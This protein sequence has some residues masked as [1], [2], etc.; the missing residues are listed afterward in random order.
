MK[1][2]DG[3]R[4]QARLLQFTFDPKLAKAYG[5]DLISPGSYRLNSIL[6]VIQKQG[7]LS[8]AH[9]PHHY[10]HEPSI[11]KKILTDWERGGR[12]YVLTNSLN[13]G[14]Y[15]QLE[16]LAELRGL[17]KKESLHTVVVNLSS[18]EVM[19][20]HLPAHLLHGGGVDPAL[21]SRRKCSLK[22]AYLKA[23]SFVAQSLQEGDARWAQEA[24][25]Q[26][27]AE[28]DKLSSYFQGQTNSSDYAAK[29]Q[30]LHRRFEPAVRL[31]ALRG[32]LL[33]IPRFSYR[34]VVVDPSGRE[35]RQ[36]VSY[37]P[38]ANRKELD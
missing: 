9:I 34:L 23:A 25:S 14:Q 2:L 5:A 38:I 4:A 22:K 26:L 28:K 15:L 16:L 6:R 11:R 12:A 20:F 35:Q 36:N 7:I 17:K 30:E 27:Q 3:W 1:E 24:R 18:C 13:Y 19:K 37:D 10:F 8:Q 21:V 33:Y 32:A 31:N 29:E